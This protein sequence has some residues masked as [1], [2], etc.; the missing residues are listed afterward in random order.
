MVTRAIV[1]PQI[2]N[3]VLVAIAI[4]FCHK[5]TQISWCAISS[6]LELDFLLG[7]EVLPD[8]AHAGGV[9]ASGPLH[10]HSA[11]RNSSFTPHLPKANCSF[12]RKCSLSLE[13]HCS[14]MDFSLS[15]TSVQPL[16][17][18]LGFRWV[19]LNLPAEEPGEA[20]LPGHLTTDGCPVPCGGTQRKL[21][22]V[23][24]GL[25]SRYN[26]CPIAVGK[27]PHSG[28]PERVILALCN[29]FFCWGPQ[30][31]VR[32]RV[33]N[34]ATVVQ[35]EQDVG[36]PWNSVTTFRSMLQ[37][38][39]ALATRRTAPEASAAEVL[40]HPQHWTPRSLHLSPLLSLLVSFCIFATSVY[41][42][43][44][45]GTYSLFS[46]FICSSSE[47]S[48]TQGGTDSSS[49]TLVSKPVSP[50]EKWFLCLKSPHGMSLIKVPFLAM[51]KT[52]VYVSFYSPVIHILK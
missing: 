33:E 13:F 11:S 12:V 17:R 9:A 42:I 3:Y 25:C 15:Q 46:S 6:S 37:S 38:C 50:S 10:C 51:C 1:T 21:D 18:D 24:A 26:P 23:S 20:S 41:F 47:M 49:H 32:S 31:F 5:L 2:L 29:R 22:C 35:A 30:L 48:S 43:V 28:A 7:T 36:R 4:I 14:L 8:P 45:S 19:Q 34:K 39:A 27:K 40:G 44:L 16:G 52:V